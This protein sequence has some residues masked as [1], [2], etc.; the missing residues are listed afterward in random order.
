MIFYFSHSFKR[1][2]QHIFELFMYLHGLGDLGGLGFFCLFLFFVFVLVFVLV[3]VSFFYVWI[4]QFTYINYLYLNK[5][6]T[7]SWIHL[8]QDEI[9]DEEDKDILRQHD[10]KFGPPVNDNSYPP[11]KRK[12]HEN[13]RYVM[14]CTCIKLSWYNTGTCNFN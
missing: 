7:V 6:M 11:R 4:N 1:K 2:N 5:S 14:N 8:V 12:H 10:V 9:T 3:F 13:N